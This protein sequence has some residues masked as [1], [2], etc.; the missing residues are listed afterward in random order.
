MSSNHLK[1]LAMPQAGLATKDL[2]LGHSP[3]PGATRSNF[4][5]RS[6]SSFGRA[7]LA[8]TAREVRFILHNELAKIDGRVVKTPAAVLV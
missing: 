7:W 6:R 1:R 2:G 3:N 8:K 4:A 5:C